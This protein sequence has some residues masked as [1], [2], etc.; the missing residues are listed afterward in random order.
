VTGRWRL[1][2]RERGA[3]VVADLELASG[4]WSRLRGLQFRSALPASSGL[5]LI[6]CGSIHT[7]CMRFAIDVIWL[8]ARGVVLG[9]RAGVRPWRIALAPR[10]TQAVLEVPA[11]SASIDVGTHLAVATEKDEDTPPSLAFLTPPSPDTPPV[12]APTSAGLPACSPAVVAAVL[13]LGLGFLLAAVPPLW[14]SDVWAHLKFGEWIVTHGALPE[15]EPFCPFAEPR[16]AGMHSCWLTQS[17][18]YLAY[19]LGELLAGGDALRQTAGGVEMLRLGHG[20]TTALRFAVLLLAF[21]RRTGAL[22]PACAFLAVVLAASLNH[23]AVLRPQVAGEL[24]FACLL[25]AVSRPVLSN[26]AL[27][28]VPLCLVTWANMHG[29]FL[30]GL[31]LLGSCLA[32]R[33]LEAIR[34]AGTWA[35]RQAL[36]DPKLRR[37]ALAL[38]LSVVAIAVLNPQGIGVYETTVRMASHPNLQTMREWGPLT[39]SREW[40][41]HWHYLALWL[42]VAALVLLCRRW[43]TPTQWVLLAG[44]GVMPLIHQR[45]M[46]WWIMAA[47]WT[48]ATHWPILRDR[49]RWTSPARPNGT[50]TAVAAMVGC[51]VIV[52]APPARW[53]LSGQPAPLQESLFAATPW[54]IA[55][56][57]KGEPGQ[58]PALARALAE[59]YADGRFTGRIFASELPGDYLLWALAPERPV[60]VYTHVHLFSADWWQQCRAVK[61]GNAGWDRFLDAFRVNLVVVEAETYSRLCRGLAADPHWLVVLNE[62]GSRDKADHRGRLFVALRRNPL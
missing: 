11:G 49:L 15:Q 13:I 42:L 41:W 21:R 51:L 12:G 60:L 52:L 45:M 46:V 38:V 27:L 39:F 22:G 16:A 57:I 20:L 3:V 61:A 58:Q 35:P 26:R 50:N 28:L 8:D 40:G 7:F 43:P 24:F 5:L 37:L 54:R 32:G 25:L 18:W 10:G 30:I 9:V 55:A 17:L 56:Q 44:F 59:L 1:I 31:A 19:H 23:V 14:H 33:L 36:H 48:M 29:S 62:T 2:D 6:P 53:L 47:P 34:P 4:F